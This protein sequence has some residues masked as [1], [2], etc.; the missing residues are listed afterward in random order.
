[1]KHIF[2]KSHTN[3]ERGIE[4]ALDELRVTRNREDYI[5]ACLYV[6]KNLIDDKSASVLLATFNLIT[7]ML[8]KLKPQQ[9]SYNQ[10]LVDEILEKMSDYLGHTNEKIR[11]TV[12]D[13]FGNVFP[14]YHLIGKDSCYRG[15]TIIGK[16]DK[17]PKVLAGRLKALNKLVTDY[18]L[19]R[20]Y[21][22]VINFA[23]KYADDKNKD[24]RTWAIILLASIAGEIGYNRLQPHLKNLR[25]PIIKSIEEK[26][27]EA[28][29]E[30]SNFDEKPAKPRT[31]GK[32]AREKPQE[33]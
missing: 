16:R 30:P 33:F 8:K 5:G 10:P 15:L 21:E 18:Q 7:E 28:G 14:M 20:D 3:R 2:S 4:M 26:L 23:V 22:S 1:M 31:T 11:H 19:G 25:P 29:N 27:D 9:S 17:P 12:E 13:A 24:V 32:S 6:A